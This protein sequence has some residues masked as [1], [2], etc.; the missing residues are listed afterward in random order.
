MSGDAVRLTVSDATGTIGMRVGGNAGAVGMDVRGGDTRNIT[1][2]AA[3]RLLT[4]RQIAVSGDAVGSA[5]FDGSADISI[6]TA[7]ERL[8]NEELEAMLL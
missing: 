3:E 1:A 5:A 4:P 2:K 8:T 6:A 7:V